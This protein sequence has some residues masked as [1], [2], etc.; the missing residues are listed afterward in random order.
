VKRIYLKLLITA[1]PMLTATAQTFAEEPDLVIGSFPFPPLLHTT[2]AGTFSGT[3]GETVK[4]LCKEANLKCQF[5]VAPLARVYQEVRTGK[6]DALITLDLGQFHKCCIL[7]QWH[8]PWSA[9]LFSSLPLKKTPATPEGM[10]GQSLIVVNGMRT[11]Y[12]FMPDLDKWATER[13]IHLS[14]ARD[15]P[16]SV[17]MFTRNRAP[18]LWGGEDFKWYINKINPTMRFI[19]KPLMTKNVALWIRKDKREIAN[20][21]NAAFDQLVRK[22]LL[23]ES[24]LLNKTLMDKHYVDAPFDFKTNK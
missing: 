1:I 18:L 13:K 16:T 3:M 12:S 14:T 8:S 24:N 20:Q 7:S 11:P 9:G 22:S 6:I 17:K 10:L 19:Y 21:L 2:E 5:R 15:I 4:M 23:T